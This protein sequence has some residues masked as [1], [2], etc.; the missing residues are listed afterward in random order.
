M[1]Q[2]RD[3][4]QPPTGKQSLGEARATRRKELHAGEAELLPK[5]I[6]T[7]KADPD[8][9]WPLP[10]K[11]VPAPPPARVLIGLPKLASTSTRVLCRP[12]S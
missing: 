4:T 2:R 11:M 6:A 9:L 12:Y 8:G 3:Y 1:S 5:L 7:L 10:P